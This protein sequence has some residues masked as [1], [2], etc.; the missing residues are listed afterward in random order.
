MRLDRFLC[1]A[2]GLSRKRIQHLIKSGLVTVD[3]N[4]AQNAAAQVQ[5]EQNIALSGECISSPRHLYLMLHKPPHTVCATHDNLNRPATELL[6]GPNFTPH[7][8]LPL[9]IVGRLDIDTTGLLLLTTDGQWNHKITSPKHR[10]DKTYI[11]DLAEP[12]KDLDKNTLEAGV[13]LKGENKPTLPCTIERQTETRIQITVQEGKYHQIKRMLAC[14]G[15]HVTRLHRIKIGA[16]ELDPTLK[17]SEFRALTDE[18]VCS[19]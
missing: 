5:G 17:E 6:Q 13:L 8:T 9:Q 14:V 15:N 19:V 7:P 18:E 10:C 1:N 2:T 11:A 3:G 16:I 4:L 12:L